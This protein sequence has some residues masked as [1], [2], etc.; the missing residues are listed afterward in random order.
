MPRP[1]G[2]RSG[3]EPRPDNRGHRVTPPVQPL[4]V[5]ALASV[6]AE[7]FASARVSR[8]RSRL[9]VGDQRKP[10]SRLACRS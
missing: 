2:R 3:A 8:S 6:V 9:R 1:L 5:D 10:P 4:A 7:D